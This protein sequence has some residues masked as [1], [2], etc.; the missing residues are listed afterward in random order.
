MSRKKQFTSLIILLIVGSAILPIMP[1]FLIVEAKSDKPLKFIPSTNKTFTIMWRH[2]VEFQPWKESFKV[3]SNGL[4]TLTETRIRS[5]GAGVPDVEGKIVKNENG[6]LTIHGIER[7]MPYYS[8][9]HSDHSS[10]TLIINKQK[11]SFVKFIPFNLS[12]KITYKRITL[13][14]YIVLT[15]TKR[16]A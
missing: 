13:L 2:S 5:Y 10:Y 8:L 14:Q 3:D 7:K 16:G 6:I 4:F 15:I 9:F 12:V 1:G 11:Y